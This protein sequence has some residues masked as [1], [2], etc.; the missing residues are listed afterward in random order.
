MAMMVVMIVR[1]GM[2][3]GMGGRAGMRHRELRPC[4]R[5]RW[6]QGADKAAALAPDQPRAEGR[7]QAV[8]GDLDPVLV[9]HMVLAVTFNS[10]APMPTIST[11]TSACINAETKDNTMPR[12]AV[13]SLAT[14]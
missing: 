8:A 7:N 4:H 10:H 13:S 11:A 1:V 9:L 3:M 6:P 14:R 2:G 5:Q 12:L